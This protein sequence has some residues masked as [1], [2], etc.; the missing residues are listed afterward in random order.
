MSQ[1]VETEL[2]DVDV[3]IAIGSGSVDTAKRILDGVP[4]LKLILLGDTAD[5]VE[6]FKA[7][8]LHGFVTY[9]MK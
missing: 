8:N 1:V 6:G 5:N 2:S 4:K 9:S 3:V 7:G